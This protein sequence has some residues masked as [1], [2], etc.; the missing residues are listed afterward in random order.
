MRKLRL[1][2]DALEVETFDTR[3]GGE[4]T[5]FDPTCEGNDLGCGRANLEF[6]RAH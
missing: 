5:A 6:V 3:T 1:E 4:P 2:L